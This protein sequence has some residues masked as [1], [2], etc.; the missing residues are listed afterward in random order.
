MNLFD[1]FLELCLN[2]PVINR[3]D[4]SSN[5]PDIPI[6]SCILRGCCYDDTYPQA[7]KCFYKT[8]Q[9]HFNTTCNTYEMYSSTQV[10]V[11][12]II[13]S[14][15]L[16]ATEPIRCDGLLVAWE[17][18]VTVKHMCTFSVWR[19]RIGRFL[20]LVNE[21]T[22]NVMVTGEMRYNLTSSQMIKVRKGDMVSADCF[23]LVLDTVNHPTAMYT[24]RI[25]EFTFNRTSFTVDQANVFHN[26]RNN[27]F[28]HEGVRLHLR[29]IINESIG[30]V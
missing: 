5:W 13:R 12:D 11:S 27:L 28:Q 30:N 9:P 4:C 24:R 23:Y 22:I 2:V 10:N 14:E 19:P 20:Q 1:I 15:L 16:D 18:A 17:F 6:D 3:I 26:N 25:G 8:D 7:F 29:A 21:I